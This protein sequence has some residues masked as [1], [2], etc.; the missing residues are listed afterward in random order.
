MNTYIISSRQKGNRFGKAIREQ[1]VEAVNAS[2][3]LGKTH[4]DRAARSETWKAIY[5]RDEAGIFQLIITL[6]E[7]RATL[8]DADLTK[9]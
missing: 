9:Y 4:S 8:H 5:K 3:A 2:D 6:D 7:Y 1:T